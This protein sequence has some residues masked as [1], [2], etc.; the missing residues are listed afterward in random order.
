MW[1]ASKLLFWGSHPYQG[2]W[3]GGGLW[4]FSGLETEVQRGLEGTLKAVWT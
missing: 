2:P 3:E 4:P 1:E